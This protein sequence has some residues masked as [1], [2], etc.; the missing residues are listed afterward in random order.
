MDVLTLVTLL[1]IACALSV[2]LIFAVGPALCLALC[3]SALGTRDR[4]IC[5]GLTIMATWAFVLWSQDVLTALR[6]ARGWLAFLLIATAT[7]SAL[8]V[9]SIQH[10][11][12]LDE[13]ASTRAKRGRK[14][15][16]S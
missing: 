8:G 9:R 14:T 4:A 6:D 3:W 16:T 5:A 15:R 2:A 13:A 11:A 7:I 1:W 12:D 10:Y